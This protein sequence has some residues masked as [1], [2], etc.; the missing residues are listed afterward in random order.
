[1]ERPDAGDLFFNSL[2]AA[3]SWAFSLLIGSWIIMVLQQSSERARL[4]AELEASRGEVARLS[5]AHGALAER[6]RLTRE[7][8][9]P[10]PRASPAC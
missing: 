1:M 8:M 9:T 5:A 6:E 4:I 2:F 7:I 3:V 10:S